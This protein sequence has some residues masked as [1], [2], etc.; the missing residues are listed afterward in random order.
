VVLWLKG[1]EVLRVT[2]RK[3]QWGEVEELHLQHL[4]LRQEGPER[5]G[6][7]KVRAHLDRHSVIGQRA[8]RCSSSKQ[9]LFTTPPLL[10]ALRRSPNAKEIKAPM[11]ITAIFLLVALLLVT[12]DRG[13]AYATYG[14]AQGGRLHAGPHRS[15]PRRSL[16]PLCNPWPT[17]S[18]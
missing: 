9:Q 1:N 15:G 17:G 12:L 16:R 5:T 8:L 13:D 10:R 7:W 18:R 2:G 6:P 3:D 4:P 11:I 14:G